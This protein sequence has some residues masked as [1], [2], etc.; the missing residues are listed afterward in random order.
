MGGYL[1]TFP[2]ARIYTLI[3]IV[4][5]LARFQIPAYVVLLYWIFLQTLNSVASLGVADSSLSGGVAFMAHVGG[6]VAGVPL[7]LLLRDSRSQRRRRAA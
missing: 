4:I 7:M 3:P 1:I 2:K 6:F 5:Y